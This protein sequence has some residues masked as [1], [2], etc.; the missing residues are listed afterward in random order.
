MNISHG[1]MYVTTAVLI[2]TLGGMAFAQEPC[3]VAQKASDNKSTAAAPTNYPPRIPL[4]TFLQS[5]RMVKSLRKGVAAMKA[6]PPYDPLSW[7]Y[8]AAIHGVPQTMLDDE[9]GKLDDAGKEKFDSVFQKRYWNQC[10]HNG[11]ESA[12]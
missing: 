5:E 9:R 2:A 4:S 7:F 10:P 6:R 3:Q 8:Q 1:N 12:N 11:E